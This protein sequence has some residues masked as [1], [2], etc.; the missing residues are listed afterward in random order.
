MIIEVGRR[1]VSQ[2]DRFCNVRL[3]GGFRGRA[4]LARFRLCWLP[5]A[6]FAAATMSGPSF[7]RRG[8][9]VE[10]VGGDFDLAFAGTDC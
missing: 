10:V 6:R 9:E 4:R 1:T 3:R 5:A 2:L 8:G 7:L